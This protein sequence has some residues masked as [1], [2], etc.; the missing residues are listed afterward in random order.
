MTTSVRFFLNLMSTHGLGMVANSKGPVKYV[1]LLV[2]LSC[3]I[4]GLIQVCRTVDS[5][6]QRA[7]KTRVTYENFE[8]TDFPAI[9]FCPSSIF[10]RHAVGKDSSSYTWAYATVNGF[11]DMAEA[12][13]EGAKMCSD[14]NGTLENVS[15]LNRTHLTMA[16]FDSSR[17]VFDCQF[18]GHPLNC[19]R[20][21]LNKRVELGWCFTFNPSVKNMGIYDLTNNLTWSR[22]AYAYGTTAN[23]TRSYRMFGG[24]HNSLSFILNLNMSQNCVPFAQNLAGVIAL[25]HD[26]DI[27]PFLSSKRLINLHPGFTTNVAIQFAHT[28]RYTEAM[29]LCI[30]Q[31]KPDWDSN[32]VDYINRDIY[33][34]DCLTSVVVDK[35]GCLP[36]FYN[37][38]AYRM[39]DFDE[40]MCAS[41]GSNTIYR[42][43]C[44][45]QAMRQEYLVDR[46]C[47]KKI[48][49]PCSETDVSA[50]PVS[51][52]FP[53]SNSFGYLKRKLGV[54]DHMSISE[55]RHNYLNVN[56][57][58]KVKKY[59]FVEEYPKM[60]WIDLINQCGG[61]LGMCLGMSLLSIVELFTTF[62]QICAFK[63][64]IAYELAANSLFHRHYR[65]RP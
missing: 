10:F 7:T 1:T 14:P 6:L 30:N 23:E 5:F 35:C 4:F 13:E 42:G 46:H 62:V 25:V 52:I 22:S 63:L 21:F 36:Y 15:F 51:T 9:T 65:Y 64:R 47:Y 48:P 41:N 27:E 55:F 26:P 59:K 29:G 38:I 17:T 19:S 60:T 33:L 61:T 54:D 24:M 53:S 57:Y 49:K 28:K 8:E 12:S 31:F 2:F 11:S 40:N 16:F 44:M 56:F 18:N 39:R 45:D 20:L 32:I 37:P 58:L 50:R 43:V 34:V 3:A